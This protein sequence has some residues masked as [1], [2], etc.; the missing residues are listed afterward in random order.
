MADTMM[1]SNVG[2]SAI[3]AVSLVDAI[4]TLVIQVFAAMATGATIICSQYIGRGDEKSSNKAARQVVIAMA[5]ISLALSCVGVAFRKPLLKLIFGKVEAPVMENALIYFLITVLFY[6]FLAMFNARSAFY[7]AGG[8][9]KFPMK[10]LVI[11]N[12]LNIVGN[13]ILIF[14]FKMGVAGAALSTLVSR[15]F[16]MLVIFY[17]LHQPKQPIVIDQY[18]KMRPDLPLIGKVLAIGVPAGV[19]NGMFQFGKLAIQ[20][21]VSTLGTTAIAAQAM[22]NMLEMLN[23]IVAIGI[24]TLLYQHTVCGRQEM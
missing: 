10:V 13:M 8:N 17:C 18:L 7:R 15:M 24:G 21:T 2:S 9:A 16:C 4:N 20:S 1:V 14:G 6:P 12:L 23:G 3:S 22:T 5:F 11:S 19:E